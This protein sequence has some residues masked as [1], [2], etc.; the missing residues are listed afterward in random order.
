MKYRKMPRVKEELSVL[1]FG[2]MRFPVLNNDMSQ[3]D[4]EKSVPMLRFAIDQGIN[5]LD[6]AFPYH[7]KGTLEGGYSEPFVGKVLQNGYREKVMLASKLP[8]WYITTRADMDR[9]LNM[10]LK[11]LCGEKSLKGLSSR[12]LALD[13]FK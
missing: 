5:Y 4:E 7:G 3:I 12:S 6:T 1:G 11:R 2:C 9:F 13:R 8:S 10:Q